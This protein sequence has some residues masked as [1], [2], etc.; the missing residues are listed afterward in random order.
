M[1]YLPFRTFKQIDEEDVAIKYLPD[2]NSKVGS[3]EITPLMGEVHKKKSMLK[4]SLYIDGALKWEYTLT[5]PASDGDVL[6]KRG[7]RWWLW[8]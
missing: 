4:Y 2:G 1:F 6:G 7:A 3:V 8:N 5:S